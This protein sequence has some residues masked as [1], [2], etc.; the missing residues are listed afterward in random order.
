MVR[1]LRAERS[2]H[3]ALGK[4]GFIPRAVF[5]NFLFCHDIHL[6]SGKSLF[7][8]PDYPSIKWDSNPR[9]AGILRE[10]LRQHKESAS[11]RTD[12]TVSSQ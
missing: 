12:S 9:L 2:K 11:H 3:V 10:Q 8:S 7:L 1:T 4:A 6:L 5:S